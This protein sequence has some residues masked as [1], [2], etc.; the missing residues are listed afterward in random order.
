MRKAFRRFRCPLCGSSLGQERYFQIIGVW[1]ERKSLEKTLREERNTLRQEK[2]K[3]SFEK[4]SLKA[5]MEKRLKQETK[6]ALEK[7]R[8]KE[9]ARSEKLSKMIQRKTQDIQLANKKIKELEEQLK[10]GTTPQIEGLNLEQELQ[11]QL[12]KEFPEDKIQRYGKVAD[13]IQCVIFKGKQIGVILYECKR[14]TRFSSSF[15]DQTKKAM[16]QRRASYGVLVTTASKKGTA[17]FWVDKDI[18]VVHPFGA[19]YVAQILRVSIIE[20]HTAQVSR[21]EVQKRA[22]EL[23]EYIKGDEFKNSVEDCIYRTRSLCHMLDR[24]VTSHKRIW[25]DRF[26]HYKAIHSNVTHMQLATSNIVKGLPKQR[27]LARRKLE[28]LPPPKV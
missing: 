11:K 6:I 5:E 14:T 26:D 1:E 18:I 13:V 16:V 25:L 22:H 9:K 23:M 27:A 28:Q 17:G 7:G 2:R 3:L 4:K 20:L 8:A 21:A 24:E 19:M 12:K 15:V 10:K